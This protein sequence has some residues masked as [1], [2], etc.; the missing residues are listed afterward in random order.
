MHFLKKPRNSLKTKKVGMPTSYNF[1]CI[2]KIWIQICST[3]PNVVQAW[4]H[5][6][7]IKPNLK[8]LRKAGFL[9][10]AKKIALGE[11]NLEKE[12]HAT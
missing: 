1:P 11:I 4:N 12:A 5:E 8:E 6:T 3:H 10:I 2:T 9:Q 7:D